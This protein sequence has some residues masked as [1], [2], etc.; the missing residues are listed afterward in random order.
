MACMLQGCATFLATNLGGTAAVVSTA[1]AID[2]A[3]T[4]ADVASL[5]ATN[6]TFTDHMVSY[7]L[8][9]DCNFLHVLDEKN[10]CVAYSTTHT[11]T[12]RSGG[13][14]VS[15]IEPK[16]TP[17]QEHV[18]ITDKEPQHVKLLEVQRS[19]YHIKPKSTVVATSAKSKKRTKRHVGR[20]KRTHIQRTVVV[21]HR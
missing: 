8:G 15:Y 11:N 2:T 1:Q 10:I 18:T 7:I 5:G 13:L 4:A 21:H 20:T 12:P 17:S 14:Q 3:K 19:Q 9:K 16:P 6:K